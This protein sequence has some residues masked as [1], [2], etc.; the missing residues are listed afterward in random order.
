ME[1]ILAPPSPSFTLSFLVPTFRGARWPSMARPPAAAPFRFPSLSLCPY[2][3]SSP[4]SRPPLLLLHHTLTR[5]CPPEPPH[6]PLPPPEKAPSVKLFL[7]LF[8][9]SLSHST[10]IRASPVPGTHSS[11]PD[12][13]APCLPPSVCHPSSPSSPSPLPR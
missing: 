3:R 7:A 2:L 8:L 4:S 9:L 1:L 5:L 6:S 11:S 12:R 13:A 10:L